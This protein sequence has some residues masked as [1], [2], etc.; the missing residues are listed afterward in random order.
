MDYGEY[1]DT[2]ANLVDLIDGFL[3]QVRRIGKSVLITCGVLNQWH[4]DP[5]AWVLGWFIPTTNSGSSSWGFSCW[6]PI[7]AYGADPY[8]ANNRGRQRDVIAVMA[9]HKRN[10]PHPTP[11]PSE[12]WEM[13]L[14]RGS[15]FTGDLVLDPFLGSGKTLV[16]A[17]KLGRKAIGI[18][19]EEKYCAIA[20]KRL[21]QSVMRL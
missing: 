10:L 1:V 13:L 20:K 14:L 5:P 16:C 6:Q 3:N 11:K 17:K 18:E 9:T 4:Y 15:V 21:A 12:V 19:V 2:Q 8:L 7:L